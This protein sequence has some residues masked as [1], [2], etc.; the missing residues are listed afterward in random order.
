MTKPHTPAL[1]VRSGLDNPLNDTAFTFG[2]C[3]PRHEEA[4][5][6]E[7]PGIRKQVSESLGAAADGETSAL[8]QAHRIR[9]PGSDTH[10]LPEHRAAML[11]SVRG[12]RGRLYFQRQSLWKRGPDA[13]AAHGIDSPPTGAVAS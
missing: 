4:R 3:R 6:G 2:R 12:G 1:F 13:E 7:R 11:D 8:H 5:L 10:L 9:A